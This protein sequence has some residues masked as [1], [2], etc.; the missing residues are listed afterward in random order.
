MSLTCTCNSKEY[1]RRSE[2]SW[3]SSNPATLLVPLMRQTACSSGKR[4]TM[5]KHKP[6]FALYTKK[7]GSTRGRRIKRSLVKEDEVFACVQF[8]R[9]QE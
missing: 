9:A 4:S 3:Y 1:L 2:E 6:R 5:K 8:V 7:I